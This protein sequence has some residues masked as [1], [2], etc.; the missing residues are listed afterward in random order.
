MRPTPSGVEVDL[1]LPMTYDSSNSALKDTGE[2]LGYEAAVHH[3]NFRR[4]T[5]NEVNRERPLQIFI[6]ALPTVLAMRSG[7]AM[8]ILCLTD[9]FT[10]AERMRVLG[11][12]GNR[13][14]EKHYQSDFIGNLQH[15]V[16]LR[17]S[18][19]ALCREAARMS[20]NRDLLVPADLTDEQLETIRRMSRIMKLRRQRLELRDEM[21]SLVGTVRAAEGTYPELYRQHNE[22]CKKLTRVRKALRDETKEKRR[23]EYYDIMPKIEVDKQIDQFLN[24]QNKDLSDAESEDEDWNPP[25]PQYEFSERARIVEAFYGP[26]A[27]TLDDDLEITRRI[28]IIKDLT[29]L[30]GLSE[31]PRRGKRFNW[32][33]DDDSDGESKPKEVLLGRGLVKCPIDVCI[34][35][36]DTRSGRRPRKYCR[37]Y[38][39]RRYLINVHFK[40]M[41]D[42]A[43]IHCTRHFS[44]TEN[45]FTEAT[46]FLH[47]AAAVH[48]YDPKIRPC[49]F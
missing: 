29:A 15:V 40:Y 9:H 12:S 43:A 23:K 35:C 32:N 46:T 7:Y 17:S 31:S 27:E 38:S 4:W 30:C 5:A 37:I 22:V 33:K 39:L 21:R 26:D 44:K 45:S 28:Q 1:L 16:L 3:Y 48:D 49:H 2:A 20:R 19:E 11:Q 8:L 41:T 47:H 13:V 10:E 14:F 34:V 18:Q 25:I 42:G 24:Q 6:L 36:D